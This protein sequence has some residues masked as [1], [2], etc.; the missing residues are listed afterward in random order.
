MVFMEWLIFWSEN[1]HILRSGKLY[2]VK[3]QGQNHMT[4]SVVILVA[5]I[6]QKVKCKELEVDLL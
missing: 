6:I 2:F 1:D 3:T 4:G 5:I